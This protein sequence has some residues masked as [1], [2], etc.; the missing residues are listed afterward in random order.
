MEYA[1]LWAGPI[2]VSLN[3]PPTPN[4]QEEWKMNEK[5][6]VLS[7]DAGFLNCG[8]MC[9][10][11][12]HPPQRLADLHKICRTHIPRPQ[13]CHHHQLH[14]QHCNVEGMRKGVRVPNPRSLECLICSFHR[15]HIEDPWDLF[16]RYILF[17]AGS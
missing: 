9:D 13:F 15:I 7:S 8:N 10:E 2:D 17:F 16:L 4:A 5:Y 14:L 11:L 1:I 6:M 12:V 3:N